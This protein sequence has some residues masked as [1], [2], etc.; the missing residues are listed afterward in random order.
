LCERSSGLLGGWIRAPPRDPV[1]IGPLVKE[2]WL[3]NVA[4]LMWALD[5]YVLLSGALLVALA[6]NISTCAHAVGGRNP[7]EEVVPVLK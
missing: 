2:D 5:S 4:P 1:R 7:R 3:I 6:L